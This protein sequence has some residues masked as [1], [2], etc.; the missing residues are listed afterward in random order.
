L[1]FTKNVLLAAQYYMRV[2]KQSHSDCANHFGFSLEH[3]R[4]VEENIE[5][6]ADCGHSEAKVNHNRCVRLLNK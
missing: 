6:A 5:I 1:V 3:G 4:D 2:D